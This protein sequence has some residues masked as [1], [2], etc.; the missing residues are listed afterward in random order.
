MSHSVSPGRTSYAAKGLN[1]AL[2]RASADVSCGSLLTTPV[3][4]KFSLIP[5]MARKE[6]L[7]RRPMSAPPKESGPNLDL[8]AQPVVEAGRRWT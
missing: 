4:D 2:M 3:F 5:G 1:G 7:S 6:I 8:K